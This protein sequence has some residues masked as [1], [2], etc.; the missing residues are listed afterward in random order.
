[1]KVHFMAT[2]AALAMFVSCK[3][4]A[5]LPSNSPEEGLSNKVQP[6][7]SNLQLYKGPEVNIGQGKGRSWITLTKE[8]VPQEA[9]IELNNA[10]LTGLPDEETA[11]LLPLHRAVMQVTPFQHIT[12]NWN[13]HG[14]EP[15]H[16][17]DLPHFDFHF[18][19]MPLAERLSIPPYSDVTASL[20]DNFPSAGYLPPSYVPIP[21]GVPQMGKHW[22]DLNAPELNGQPF[23]KTFIYGSYNG[24]VTFYEPMA[25]MALIQN[26]NTYSSAIPQP[27]FYLPGH[28]YYPTTYSVYSMGDSHYISLSNFVW[29]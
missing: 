25:T 20:F 17:Y 2:T 3:K 11:F 8:G 22:V 7:H 16:V 26:G 5:A 29:R 28:T 18:Y 6:A 14:H 10:A 24:Q 15:E 13:P 12:V 19:M 4:E 21:G 27:Q 9:G 23:T 1:M